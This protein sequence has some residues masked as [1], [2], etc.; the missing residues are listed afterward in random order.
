[1][2]SIELP[3]LRGYQVHHSPL[4]DEWQVTSASLDYFFHLC[5]LMFPTV[6]GGMRSM[7][8]RRLLESK[9]Y[10][11]AFWGSSDEQLLLN[12]V[13]CLS[14][15]PVNSMQRYRERFTGFQLHWLRGSWTGQKVI[16]LLSHQ[17]LSK[18]FMESIGDGD[19]KN[20][21]RSWNLT[22]ASER[23]A[24]CVGIRTNIVRIPEILSSPRKSCFCGS[25]VC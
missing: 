24:D 19:F 1:M 22:I 8:S 5:D 16:T 15:Q 17:V 12:H 7:R 23:K 11:L 4:T 25:Q 9:E 21:R 6:G 2:S 13:N 14:I 10:G 20:K 3:G 18:E